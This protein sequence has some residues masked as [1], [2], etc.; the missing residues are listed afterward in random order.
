RAGLD[1]L[2]RARQA[3]E[4]LEACVRA[5]RG[6]LGP[7]PIELVLGTRHELGLSWVVPQ[8]DRL[9]R[10]HPELTL[11]LYFGAADDLLLRLRM[12]EIDCAITSSRFNDPRLDAVRLHREEYVFVASRKLLARTPL[13]RAEHAASHALLDASADMP[14]FRYWR[15]AP[16]GGDRLRFARVQR[17]GTIAAIEAL[18]RAGRGVA[19]LPRYLVE[20]SLARG[21]L[22]RVFPSVHPLSD[23]FRLVFRT[24][25][26][27][28]PLFESLGAEMLEVPLA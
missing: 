5:A 18:V 3:L 11:H 17:I 2:P 6:D 26:P 28:R 25:D 22:R 20:K 1:L 9:A 7:A 24:D 8:L 23:Y 21:E 13:T 19:V 10:L 14:L 12:R 27:R 16:G 15:D 4:A